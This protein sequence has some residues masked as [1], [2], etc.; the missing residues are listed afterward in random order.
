MTHSKNVEIRQAHVEGDFTVSLGNERADDG[1]DV[2]RTDA[3]RYG[4]F[5]V[6]LISDLWRRIT[7]EEPTMAE[8]SA[9]QDRFRS[10]Q[11]VWQDSDGQLY[12][13]NLGILFLYPE[14][15]A[16]LPQARICCEAFLQKCNDT[17]PTTPNDYLETEQPLP[18]AIESALGFIRRNTKGSFRIDGLDRVHVTE[19]PDKAVREALVNAVAHR[20]YTR[21]GERVRV[22]VFKDD[23]IVIRSPGKL[24]KGLTVAKLRS[25]D[26]NAKSR[27]PYLAAYLSKYMRLEQ[28][29]VPT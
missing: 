16:P 22:K 1:F 29:S 12:A 15:T 23:R 8:A 13:T 26:Y 25:G 10:G 27:N 4:Q 6:T 3:V 9:V 18:T 28:P 11:L 21:S 5:D 14:P 17:L 2:A 20:D 19:Y 7:G 24:M